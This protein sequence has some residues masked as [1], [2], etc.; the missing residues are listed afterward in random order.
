M[1]TRCQLGIVLGLA[2]VGLSSCTPPQ[3]L[4]PPL[5]EEYVLPPGDDPRFSNPPAYPKEALD[6]GMKKDP[7]KAADLKGPNAGRFGA[8]PTMGAG[9]GY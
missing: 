5:R 2:I 3:T 8:G 9:G 1:R 7:S 6:S 4:K